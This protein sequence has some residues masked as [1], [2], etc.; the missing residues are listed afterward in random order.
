MNKTSK[1][2][3]PTPEYV[4]EKQL[5]LSGFETPLFPNIGQEQ[6]MGTASR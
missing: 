2:R 6:S 3:A 1:R 5:V 4:S